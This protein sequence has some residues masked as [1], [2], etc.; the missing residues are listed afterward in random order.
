MITEY[1]TYEDIRKFRDKVF[2][3]YNEMKNGWLG[4]EARRAMI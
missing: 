3:K 1:S 2:T 4:K